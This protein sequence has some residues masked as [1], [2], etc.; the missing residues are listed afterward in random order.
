MDTEHL[1]S[2]LA[3]ADANAQ[4]TFFREYA[5]RVAEHARRILG[6]LSPS[7]SA[8]EVAS[9]VMR[10]VMTRVATPGA[11]DTPV[12]LRDRDEL[13]AF[14]HRIT[15]NRALSERRKHT[16]PK[17]R[18]VS[19]SSYIELLESESFGEVFGP[20]GRKFAQL[21]LLDGKSVLVAAQVVTIDVESANRLHRRIQAWLVEHQTQP[22]E[23]VSLD[24]A[25]RSD[26][27]GQLLDM[28]GT[29]EYRAELAAIIKDELD[30]LDDLSR[31]IVM[32]RLVDGCTL[33]E[34]ARV[35]GL[36]PPSVRH[37]LEDV[38][39]RWKDRS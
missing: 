8:T 19:V 20:Q 22:R 27:S 14:L 18:P 23:I 6:G 24:A 38:L 5:Y 10:R 21:T 34:I 2:G 12:S 31:T 37:K 9:S 1:I 16:A 25:L 36:S 32:M 17:R 35:V 26:H 13:Q 29:A 33:A 39:Q 3:N 28:L 30:R 11:G 4:E 15:L 7:A